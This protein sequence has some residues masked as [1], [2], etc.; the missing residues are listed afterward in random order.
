M[1]YVVPPGADAVA[2]RSGWAG[3]GW[4]LVDGAAALLDVDDADDDGA[5]PDDAAPELGACVTVTVAGGA[6]DDAPGADEEAAFAGPVPDPAVLEEHA[7]RPASTTMVASRLRRCTGTA[8]QAVNV[9]ARDGS[10]IDALDAR[11]LR[12][13][14]AAPRVG[15]PEIVRTSTVIALSNPVPYRVL[16]LV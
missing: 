9:S 16:P 3:T 10:R 15:V 14:V 12:A 7:V 6:D 2:V 1:T 8:C 11:L 13:Y 5:D 4:V